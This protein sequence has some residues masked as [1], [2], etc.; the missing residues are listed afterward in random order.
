M[1]KKKI[2]VEGSICWGV[3]TWKSNPMR[4]KVYAFFYR[5]KDAVKFLNDNFQ[6]NC[7]VNVCDDKFDY[8]YTSDKGEIFID[9]YEFYSK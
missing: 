2:K 1:S 6:F 4:I 5:K 8:V 3:G 9:N 7:I